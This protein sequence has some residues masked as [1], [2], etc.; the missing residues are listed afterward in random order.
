MNK[1]LIYGFPHTGTS[2]LKKLIGNSPDVYKVIEETKFIPEIDNITQNN[3]LIKYA[4]G[5]QLP[6]DFHETKYGDFK[7]ILVIKNP[8]DAF[9]S[10]MKRFNNFKFKGCTINDWIHY[11]ALFLKFQENP[12][13]RVFTVKYEDFFKD[14][15]LKIKEVFNFLNLDYDEEQ[16][17]YNKKPAFISEEKTI[18]EKEPN[19]FGESH[20][21]FRTWQINQP[22]KN[23]T[24]QS[25]KTLPKGV[26]NIL[27]S[28]DITKKLGY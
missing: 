19:R 28:L 4:G 18:P 3:I 9:A 11:G 12:H 23:M 7:I 16:I 17:I 26:K 6:F 5:T 15:F 20:V 25:A 21:Y 13:P 22:F 2:I 1:I 24:G 8:Y 27:A 14:N 10:I